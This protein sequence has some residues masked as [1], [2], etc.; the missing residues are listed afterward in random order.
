MINAN[1]HPAFVAGLVVD[2]IRT[3]SISAKIMDSNFLRIAFPPPF[4]AIILAI[5]NQFLLF[6]V[7]TQITGCPRR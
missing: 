3:Q 2:A 1:A 4:P 5:T 7:S 6:G